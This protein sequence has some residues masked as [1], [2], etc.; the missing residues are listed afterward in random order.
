MTAE[1]YQVYKILKRSIDFLTQGAAMK[2][3]TAY[4][5]VSTSKQG[6]DGLGMA[7]QEQAIKAYNGNVIARFVEVESGKRKDRP[8]LAKALEH[9]KLTGSTLIVA[10][11]DRLA[12]NVHFISS[13]MEAK[14]DFVCC[15][16]P[17]ASPLTLHIMAAV[18]EHEAKAI[19]AR[20]KV[21]LAQAKARGVKLGN[22]NLTAEGRVKGTAEGVKTIKETADA[23]AVRVVPTIQALQ[24]QGMS[25][26][27]IAAELEKLGVKT[28]RGGKWSAA[29][30]KNALAR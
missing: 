28:A 23:F 15:D 9:C 30:V 7:A 16:F 25:L 5:R 18:A 4:L 13:L 3:Y 6:V 20:T 17:E 2:K 29:A 27:G 24:G 22:P 1:S 11:L 21:A 26:R 12:R 14:V 10:K 19:S 8:E